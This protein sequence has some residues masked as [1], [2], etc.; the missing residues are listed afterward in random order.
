[1][2][3]H[4][5]AFGSSG[6]RR[7]R[8]SAL[9]SAWRRWSEESMAKRLISLAVSTTIALLS[10]GLGVYEALAQVVGQSVAGTPAAPL[11]L[12]VTMA[13]A[14]LNSNSLI[15]SQTTPTLLPG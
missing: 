2:G 1:M 5:P 14:P 10:P 3:R 7:L 15:G 8:R 12:P 13:G 4:F 6:P 11:A 9:A